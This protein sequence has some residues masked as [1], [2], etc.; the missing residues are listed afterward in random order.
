MGHRGPGHKGGIEM[1]MDEGSFKGW[2]LFDA[3]ERMEGPDA[4]PPII[5]CVD[6]GGQQYIFHFD[7][8][9]FTPRRHGK[10]KCCENCDRHRKV[11]ISHKRG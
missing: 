3:P 9:D 11:S 6:C 7:C 4:E 1:I 8:G 5:P 2:M 10:V